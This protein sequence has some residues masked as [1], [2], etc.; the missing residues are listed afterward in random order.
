MGRALPSTYHL[1][2]LEIAKDA[3]A[4]GHIMPNLPKGKSRILDVGCGAGQTL[5]ASDLS[6]DARAFGID[7][8]HSALR[9]GRSLTKRVGFVCSRAECL[10]F[11]NEYFDVV[12]SRIALPYTHIP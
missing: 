3:G 6:R 2:E 5:I 4:T 9:L 12:I 8:D 1:E 10:P 11:P 7:V